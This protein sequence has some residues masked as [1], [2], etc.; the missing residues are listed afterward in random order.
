MLDC[1]VLAVK[2]PL[3]DPWMDKLFTDLGFDEGTADQKVPRIG[4]RC[5]A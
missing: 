3:K 2:Q 4:H 1:K 5:K